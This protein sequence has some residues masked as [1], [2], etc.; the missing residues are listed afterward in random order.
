MSKARKTKQRSSPVV[1]SVSRAK[2][3][4]EGDEEDGH[5]GAL[6]PLKKSHRK[7]HR[8]IERRS[9]VEAADR[10]VTRSMALDGWTVPR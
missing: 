1:G 5:D 8:A 6:E 9:V 2:G 10:R 3:R 4:E 7:P